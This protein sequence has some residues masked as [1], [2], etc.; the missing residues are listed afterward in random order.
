LWPLA[1]FTIASLRFLK[2]S[3]ARFTG[4]ISVE[5]CQCHAN[6][7]EVLK[8]GLVIFVPFA[9]GKREWQADANPS[10]AISRLPPELP[11]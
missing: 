5:N 1:V 8:P 2:A 4:N 3:P 7:L 9:H 11:A 10:E 6:P